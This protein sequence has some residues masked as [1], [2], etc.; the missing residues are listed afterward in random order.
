MLVALSL[1]AG[2]LLMSGTVAQTSDQTR[3]SV[4]RAAA[5]KDKSLPPTLQTSNMPVQWQLDQLRSLVLSL[6]Q[7]VEAMKTQP[8][9]AQSLNNLQARLGA[10]ESAVK[11]TSSG[12]TLQASGTLDLRGALIRAQSPRFVASGTVE[13]SQL[14]TDTV[15]ASSY[16]PGAGNIW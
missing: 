9:G 14:V 5:T 4:Q 6:Q 16:T 2:A 7:E 12:V 11:I 1:M 8:A 15:V 10:L 13:S 3:I